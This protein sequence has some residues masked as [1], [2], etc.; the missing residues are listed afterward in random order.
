[1]L[2]VQENYIEQ[3]GPK[4]EKDES[5]GKVLLKSLMG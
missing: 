5:K 2:D 4:P 3:I 1:M